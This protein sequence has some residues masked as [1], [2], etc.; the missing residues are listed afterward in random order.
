MGAD[1]IAIQH[2]HLGSGR[3]QTLFQQ[4]GNSALTG[5]RQAGEP[6][7][8]ALVTDA[9]DQDARRTF[10]SAAKWMPHSFLAS[11]SHHQRPARSSSPGSTAR[12]QGAQP[13]LV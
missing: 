4:A 6:E 2:F 8:E 5:A 10:P 7:S 11:C 1:H 13:M 9:V 3:A 12:V